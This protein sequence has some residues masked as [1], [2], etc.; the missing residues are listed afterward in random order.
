MTD[1]WFWVVAGVILVFGLVVARGAP[2]VPSH[3]R[4]AKQS[5]EEL[6]PLGEN[7]VLVDLGSGDG[8]VLRLAADKGARAVGYELNPILA[9]VS[10]LLSWGNERIQVKAGDYWLSDLPANTT[11]VYAFFVSRDVRK[12]EQKIQA[13]AN[14]FGRQLFVMT[15][16]A[17]LT[18]KEP[19][20]T[21]NA[22]SL[23]VFEPE[24]LQGS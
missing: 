15:Y 4:F 3:R 12:L 16:G 7:D 18:G 20:K 14:A 21:L 13:A 2:Y 19:V 22:H 24:A 11:I 5:L 10:R 9:L 8:V 23:Y 6:Y 17:K 1:V